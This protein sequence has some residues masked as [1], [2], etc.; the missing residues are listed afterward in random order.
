MARRSFIIDSIER[1]TADGITERHSLEA[2]LILLVGQP[3]TGKTGWLRMLDF[4]L[5]DSDPV[6]QRLS[7]CTF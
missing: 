3:N 5:G 6:E 4:V 7:D 2:G 1:V